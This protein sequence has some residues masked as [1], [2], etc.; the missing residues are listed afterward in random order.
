MERTC[1]QAIYFLNWFNTFYGLD[2]NYAEACE[3]L[4]TSKRPIIQKT[5]HL[6]ELTDSLNSKIAKNA[7]CKGTVT[8]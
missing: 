1:P 5:V 6:K 2:D 8:T 7:F 4:S 3:E